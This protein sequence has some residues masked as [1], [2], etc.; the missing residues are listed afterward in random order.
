M[1]NK[2]NKIALKEAK[3]TLSLIKS[4]Y[5]LRNLYK[6]ENGKSSLLYT[7]DTDSDVYQLMTSKYSSKEK[8]LT[9]KI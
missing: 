3:K 4:H 1:I 8:V 7:N 9:K 6:L 2:D 5:L